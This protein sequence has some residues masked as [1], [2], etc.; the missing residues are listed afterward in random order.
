MSSLLHAVLDTVRRS[1][2]IIAEQWERP[3]H[4]RHKGTI[5]LVTETD[6]AVEEYLKENLSK[7]L[8][9]VAFL[10]EESAGPDA[11]QAVLAT[12]HWIIDPVDGTTNFVHGIPFVGTSVALWSGGRVVLGVVNMPL[13]GECF[14]AEHGKGAW[15]G[16]TPLH[17][18]SVQSL[19][20][21][22][23]GTGFPYNV[24]LWQERIVRWIAAVLPAA[25]GMRRM[26]AAAVDLAYVAAGRLDA[27]YEASLQPWDVAA[28]WLLVEEAG[29]R[30]TDLNG[31][32][33]TFGS[34]ILAD[35]GFIH[36]EI[37]QVLT[38]A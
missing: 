26:G 33:Y 27:F 13:L 3:R 23:V 24:P 21:A 32:P 9:G 20:D 15:C 18:S 35:N 16:G 25:Q 30:V 5:D 7:V 10:A 14:H 17:V 12:D 4:V 1:G 2:Q 28:G 22:V 29:G 37:R 31:T 11:V 6:V 38:E 36:D 34:I 8:P 19:R